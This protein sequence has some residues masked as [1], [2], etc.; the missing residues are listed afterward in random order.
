MEAF[1]FELNFHKKKWLVCCSYNP[2]KS[3][4]YRHLDTLRESLDLYSAHYE[5][6]ILIRDFNVNIDDPH[7][8][9]FYES[10]RFKNLIKDP[11]CFKNP[12]NLSCIALILT[13]SHYSFQN[14]CVIETGLSDFHKMIVSV[15]KTT[16]QKLKPRIAQ[17]R[18]YAQSSNDNFR[19]KLLENVTLEN[20][21]TSS[22]GLEKFLQICMNTLDQMVPRK[23]IHTWQ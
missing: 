8:E 2:N 21:N 10:Y 5:N 19:K 23:K 11:T 6:T 4:I 9:S 13:N 16:F 12:D 1:I 20:V 22:N 7:M 15:M 17:Y 14:S 3:N 18:D